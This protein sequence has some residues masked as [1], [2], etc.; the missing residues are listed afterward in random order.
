MKG[1]CVGNDLLHGLG[2]GEYE[3]RVE[4]EGV[5]EEEEKANFWFLKR[6]IYF[7]FFS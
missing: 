7:F 1:A 3:K 6:E 5:G 2:H 4:S